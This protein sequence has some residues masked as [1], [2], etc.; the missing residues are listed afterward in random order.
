VYD[1]DDRGRLAE[2]VRTS[3][4]GVSDRQLYTYH[5][6]CADDLNRP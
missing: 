3:S 4:L 5:G 2:V 1:Y 6:S